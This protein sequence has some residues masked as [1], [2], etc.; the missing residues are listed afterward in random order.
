ME[1]N[2]TLRKKHLKAKQSLYQESKVGW[3]L[4]SLLIQFTAWTGLRRKLHIIRT[5]VE[6]N[7]CDKIQL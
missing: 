2:T 6:N 5:A 4:G 7:P 3:V 1:S